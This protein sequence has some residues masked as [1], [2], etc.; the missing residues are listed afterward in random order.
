MRV[1]DFITAI[2]KE[3]GSVVFFFIFW[4]FFQKIGQNG[5]P[6][7]REPPRSTSFHETSRMESKINFIFGA[8]KIIFLRV[9]LYCFAL[10]G[11]FLFFLFFVKN[12]P[13]E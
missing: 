12:S 6:R 5:R 3:G 1:N 9:F 7:G 4:V 11:C 10:F 13:A 8:R 2:K